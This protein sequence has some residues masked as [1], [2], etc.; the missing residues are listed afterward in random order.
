MKI[1]PA[2]YYLSCLDLSVGAPGLEDDFGA[3]IDAPYS[4]LDIVC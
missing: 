1:M 2:G 4:S 3:A